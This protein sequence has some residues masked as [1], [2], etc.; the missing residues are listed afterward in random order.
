VKRKN[1]ISIDDKK[2]TRYRSG[3]DYITELLSQDGR[4]VVTSKPVSVSFAK[5]IDVI[6]VAQT[7]LDALELSS[8]GLENIPNDA[9]YPFGFCYIGSAAEGLRKVLNRYAL[10]YTIQNEMVYIL[11][12]REAAED[13]G[14]T[15]TAENGLFTFPQP[16]S[17]KTESNDV[18][19]EAK[20][21]WAFS[22]LLFPDLLPG[23]GCE[24]ESATFT[25]RVVIRAARY[26]G[27]NRDGS[28]SMDIEAEAV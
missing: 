13:T 17:D 5:D 14:I 25:G 27:D 1:K 8:K 3:N 22:A 16:V 2:G 10:S 20:N 4:A 12:A 24:I 7:M 9:K 21:R 26:E 28:F 15:L 18:E 11:S 6:T 19:S 23:A